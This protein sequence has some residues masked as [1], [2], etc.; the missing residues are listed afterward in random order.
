MAAPL[1][2]Q[3]VIEQAI[4]QALARALAGLPDLERLRCLK[5]TEAA[6]LLAIDPDTLARLV[7]AGE[8]E[9]VEIHGMPRVTV[10]SLRAYL[11]RARSPRSASRPSGR[12]GRVD[13]LA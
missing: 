1:D 2:L 11:D 5:K 10:A 7:E 13:R 12:T 6:T 9:V 4:S 8:I 3:A